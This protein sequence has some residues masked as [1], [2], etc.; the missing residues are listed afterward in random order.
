MISE[1]V[2]VEIEG[3]SFKV[4]KRYLLDHINW[5][6]K[7]G[8]NWVV[9]GMNGSGKTTLL[10]MIAGFGNP[11]IGVIKSIRASLYTW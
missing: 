11:T 8:E 2:I 6:I 7:K 1:E 9:F 10:S 4:G 5:K 3:L